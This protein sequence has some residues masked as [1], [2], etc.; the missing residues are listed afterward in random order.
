MSGRMD[1]EPEGPQPPEDSE[2]EEVGSPPF[3]PDPRLV[4]YLER[5]R[6]DDAEHRFRA[7]TKEEDKPL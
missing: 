3:Q 6:N 5:G 1:K 4:T 7:G 2:T